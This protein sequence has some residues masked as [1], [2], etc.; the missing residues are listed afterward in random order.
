MSAYSR[1][2]FEIALCNVILNRIKFTKLRRALGSKDI[3]IYFNHVF[4]YRLAN[5]EVIL[6]MVYKDRF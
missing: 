3:T 4:N 5:K 1:V 6:T 2:N